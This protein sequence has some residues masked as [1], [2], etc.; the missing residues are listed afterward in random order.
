MNVE[1]TLRPTT[2][3]T[4][5][6]PAINN[7]SKF[8][9]GSMNDRISSAPPSMFLG[10]D[11]AASFEKSF[12]GESEGEIVA[13]PPR[14]ETR[15]SSRRRERPLSAS[16]QL[17][18]HPYSSVRNVTQSDKEHDEQQQQQQQQ[19]QE[20][21]RK[22]AGFFDRVRGALGLGRPAREPPTSKVRQEMEKRSSL[23]QPMM[24]SRP[25]AGNVRSQSEVHIPQMPADSHQRS[26]SA[27]VGA[28][29]SRDDILQSYKQLM[30]TGFFQAHAIQSTRQPPPG[31]TARQTRALPTI[32]S[33]GRV[34]VD[35]PTRRVPPAPWPLPEPAVN[36]PLSRPP[37]RV[38]PAPPCPSEIGKAISCSPSAT[39]LAAF[40]STQVSAQHVVAESA[41]TARSTQRVRPAMSAE[42]LRY[43]LRGRGRK[44]SRNDSEDQSIQSA[45]PTD[46]K[47]AEGSSAAPKRVSK[48][49]RKMPSSG[50]TSL[51][52]ETVE[53]RAARRRRSPSPVTVTP[54]LRSNSR[55]APN[56][57]RKRSKSPGG[58]RSR[59]PVTLDKY[60]LPVEQYERAKLA[61][62]EL[63]RDHNA[64]YEGLRVAPDA[65]K[66]IPSVPSI[67]AHWKRAGGVWDENLETAMQ[68]DHE[69]QI[70][71]TL[72]GLK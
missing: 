21:V 31:T 8:T 64:P 24:S 39:G 13:E 33:P 62:I 65:N 6:P 47:I 40:T 70:E 51:R 68:V 48:K 49:L 5:P 32:P 57:L 66:G 34:S 41:S 1:D 72:P 71:Q 12:C 19:Q 3:K 20:Q 52:D 61:S 23:Q 67:P 36:S 43:P 69:N 37:T 58:A 18:N 45:T 17:Q 35:E 30:E 56:R 44:R 54:G 42:S 38:P 55:G 14:P 60:N 9:E 53:D 28:K 10:P 4:R 26:S 25:A 2:A 22:P 11:Q 16:A 27:A 7:G 46:P 29:P 15:S 59:P 50:A 63:D